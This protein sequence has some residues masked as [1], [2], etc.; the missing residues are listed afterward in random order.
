[1]KSHKAWT[2]KW[3]PRGLRN[4]ATRK[5]GATLEE[6][7][8][9]KEKEEGKAE[10]RGGMEEQ[11]KKR[12]KGRD[13]EASRSEQRIGIEHAEVRGMQAHRVEKKKISHNA[14]RG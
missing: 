1:M 6:R 8:A 11:K 10:G 7:K 5:S 2:T 4:E 14:G 12:K 13:E 9:K 3:K